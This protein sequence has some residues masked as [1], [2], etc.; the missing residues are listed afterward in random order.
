MS[1]LGHAWGLKSANVIMACPLYTP[2]MAWGLQANQGSLSWEGELER[3]LPT[4]L[5]ILL[6]SPG[7]SFIWLVGLEENIQAEIKGAI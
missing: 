1:K 2:S 4:H 6:I 7:C 5:F 3:K